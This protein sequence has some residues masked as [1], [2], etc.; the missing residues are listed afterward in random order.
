MAY[1][2]WITPT[3]HFSSLSIIIEACSISLIIRLLLHHTDMLFLV[4]CELLPLTMKHSLNWITHTS[5]RFTQSRDQPTHTTSLLTVILAAVVLL[6]MHP[7]TF[8]TAHA[9][10]GQ[11]PH[12]KWK[13]SACYTTS[14]KHSNLCHIHTLI[15]TSLQKAHWVKPTVPSFGAQFLVNVKTH[16]HMNDETDSS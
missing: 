16:E 14:V 1:S 15:Y 8:T 13:F 2:S 4:V 12:C 3:N 11:K 5:K 7:S 10:W 6:W 9:L